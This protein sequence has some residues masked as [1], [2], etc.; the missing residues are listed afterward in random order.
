[1][2]PRLGKSGCVQLKKLNIFGH[3]AQIWTFLGTFDSS[4][5]F[6]HVGHLDFKKCSKGLK[7]STKTSKSVQ[8]VRKKASRGV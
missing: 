6:V 1:M 8:H 7:K 2:L 3:I 5:T 4:D